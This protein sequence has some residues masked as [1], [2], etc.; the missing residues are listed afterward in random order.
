MP[1]EEKKLEG[2][3]GWLIWV[4]IGLV[5][6]PI[7][8]L[9]E[10]VPVYQGM[11]QDGSWTAIMSGEVDSR[12]PGFKA[13]LLFEAAAN[14]M[15]FAAYLVLIALFFMKKRLFPKLYIFT[16]AVNVLFLIGDNYLW[17]RILP[18]E[19]APDNSDDIKEIAKMMIRACIWIPY[20][21]I[22]KRVKAT[23]IH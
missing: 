21:L 5:L 10:I 3:G 8:M 6:T 20:M 7:V 12:Y 1:T 2:L 9:T 23:F 16:L 22:S 17:S 18:P 11:A 14:A 19:L 15:L 13:T 4:G